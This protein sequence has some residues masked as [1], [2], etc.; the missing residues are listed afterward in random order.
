MRIWCLLLTAIV[1][2]LPAAAQER[3]GSDYAW[4]PVVTSDG[5][6]LSYIYYGVK[7]RHSG[8]VVIRLRNGNP[9]PVD[10]RFTVVIKSLDR[11]FV[12]TVTGSVDARSDKTGDTDGLFWT[13]FGADEHIGEIG[14]RGLRVTAAEPAS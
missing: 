13:P 6:S 11:E 9:Y 8:G 7:D 12:D 1:V 14:I 2:A 3:A 5:L 10:Y 4:T